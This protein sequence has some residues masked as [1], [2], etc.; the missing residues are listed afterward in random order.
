MNRITHLFGIKYPIIQGGMVWCSGWRLASAVSNN[1]GLGLLG[2]GSMHCETLIEH[3]RKMKSAT[4]QPWGVN[5]P[6]MYPDIDRL[7]DI[8]V[9]E[10][11]K[12]VFTSAGSPKKW[13]SYLKSHGMIVAHVI[14]SA[15]F[16]QKC[17]E[18]GCDAI[19]AEGFE[20]GGH[21]GREETTTLTLIPNVAAHCTLPL[22]AA[23]GIA[24]GKAM[25]AA[26]ILGAEGV[27]IGSRFAVARESS[28]HPLFKQRVY[29]TPEGGTMLA[30]KKLAPTRLIKNEFYEQVSTLEN[31]GAGPEDLAQL[32]GKGRAKKGIFEG[33]LQEGELEIGQVSSM[34]IQEETVAAI[35]TDLLQDYQD[36]LTE[37]TQSKYTF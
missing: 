15:L 28:A 30:L 22:I 8:L 36:R 29:E 4:T 16:A 21:N 35:L 19:V 11:V 25:L 27:Q 12:I 37:L 26:M 17:E 32:L 18:A 10:K 34:L 33:N 7:M 6:L 23:G 14:S 1:G 31:Q 5:V 24:S 13:T 3:I 20:A 9:E 2:A